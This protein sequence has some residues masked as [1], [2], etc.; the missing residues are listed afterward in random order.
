[1]RTEYAR[2]T[3]NTDMTETNS[4][5]SSQKPRLTPRERRGI[6]IFGHIIAV[7]LALGISLL[8]WA[9]EDDWL[10]ISVKF[11]LERPDSWF[12]LL[13]LLWLILMVPLY[14][15]HKVHFFQNA[16]K[17]VLIS[18]VSC[19]SIYLLIFFLAPAKTLPRRGVI[20]FFVAAAIFTL[21]WQRIFAHFYF[22]KDAFINT[23]IVGA[24]KAGTRIAE[25]INST[26]GVPYHVCGY[27]DDDP[28]KMGTCIEGYPVLGG[29]DQYFE[30]VEKTQS[31]QIIMAISNHLNE[32][33][34]DALTQSEERGITVTTMP[35]IYEE[36]L[37]RVPVHLLN[38][39][40]LLRSFYDM[41]HTSLFFEIAKRI[42]DILGGLIGLLFLL[43]VTPFIA[44]ATL[45]DTG[46]PVFYSQERLGLRAGIFNIIKFRTM[47]QNAE[48]DGIAR[49][50]CENDSRITK[51][52]SFLRRSHLDE[53][54]QFINV[55]R[56]DLSLVGPR[57]ERPQIVKDLQREV[58]FYRAR[59]LVRPGITGWAQVNQ[60]YAAGTEENT[61]KLEY[62]LYYIK[63]RSLLMDLSILFHTFKTIFG[64][65]GR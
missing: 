49:P 34:F 45:L 12:Y 48:K 52:G 63:H 3:A 29:S 35:M 41:S 18:A 44:A 24:G 1:M 9:N 38:T 16:L 65:K 30:I 43:L 11:L 17:I 27:I 46:R 7:L 32:R 51:V 15:I 31:T 61:V 36:L 8:A 4:A 39:D 20:V 6:L 37:G 47:V 57:A 55:L 2:K 21:L 40:W 13:P 64:L 33:I 14:N 25:I 26:E 5:H 50:A 56:G 23:I 42:F 19:T 62:D 10:G 58:P 28:E 53:M 22:V 54:P 60:N 59:L